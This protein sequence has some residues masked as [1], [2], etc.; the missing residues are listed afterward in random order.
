MSSA[1]ANPERQQ[2]RH[3]GGLGFTAT[4]PLVFG[5]SRTSASASRMVKY[6]LNGAARA[7]LV[8]EDGNGIRKRTPRTAAMKGGNAST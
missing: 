5:S 1:I 7:R 6:G 4:R 3:N 2:V 8:G